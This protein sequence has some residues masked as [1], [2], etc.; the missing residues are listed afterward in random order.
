MEPVDKV[1]AESPFPGNTTLQIEHPP[2]HCS[3]LKEVNEHIL[4]RCGVSQA[5]MAATNFQNGIFT[6]ADSSR[7]K[8]LEYY[9][10]FLGHSGDQS[11]H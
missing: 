6:E 3:F 7:E 9:N 8:L 11:R 4:H 1:H 10:Q 2:Y 5:F